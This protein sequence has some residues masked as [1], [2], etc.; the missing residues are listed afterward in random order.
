MEDIG[1]WVG[2]EASTQCGLHSSESRLLA[3]HQ[4]AEELAE[5]TEVREGGEGEDAVLQQALQ[6]LENMRQHFPL[7]LLK[8]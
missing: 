1:R 6:Q 5:R 7:T 8:W 3:I 4:T 2:F